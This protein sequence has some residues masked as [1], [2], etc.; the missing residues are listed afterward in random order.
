M[1]AEIQKFKG[2]GKNPLILDK[3]KLRLLPRK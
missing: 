2:L 1:I 3:I